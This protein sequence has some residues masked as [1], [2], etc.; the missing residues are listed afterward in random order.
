MID[1]NIFFRQATLHICG[2]LNFEFA[3]QDCL[4][5]IKSFIPVDIIQL[6]LYD[7]GLTALRTFA[8]ATPTNTK[9]VNEIL[10]LDSKGR[11]FLDNPNLPLAMVISQPL[12]HPVS[13]PIIKKS[14]NLDDRSSMV[15]HL[16]IKGKKL[17]N[18]ILLAKGKNIYSKK[19][20]Q[21][22]SI[23][24]E[25]FAIALSNA[26]KYEEINHLKE[27]MADDLHILQ[28]KS[29]GFSFNEFIGEDFGF[30]GKHATN[31]QGSSFGESGY[32]AG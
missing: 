9:R 27:T 26:L 12:T 14:G 7:Q 2:N 22:F 23:L 5:Y 21:L 15:M 24:N 8:I 20:L 3:L 30:K 1:K 10:P 29:R 28:Q 25:P 11:K 6:N 16:I 4:I 32:A 17:G 18:L 31:S 13:G 19:H